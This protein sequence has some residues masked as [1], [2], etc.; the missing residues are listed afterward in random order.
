MRAD[1]E[2]KGQTE[3]SDILECLDAGSCDS[4]GDRLLALDRHK[5]PMIDRGKLLCC[6]TSINATGVLL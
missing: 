2:V 5:S 6:C 4:D 3:R 1:E